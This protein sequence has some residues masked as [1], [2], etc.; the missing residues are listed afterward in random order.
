VV[1][2]VGIT[3]LHAE[4][5]PLTGAVHRHHSGH[6]LTAADA[7]AV[8][9]ALRIAA[10]WSGR[11]SVVTVAPA[12]ADPALRE[13]MA[14]GVTVLRIEPEGDAGDAWPGVEAA[15]E[16]ELARLVAG[17]IVGPGGTPELVV[18]GDRSSDRGTGAFPAF[19][20]HELGSA[21]ALGL[22]SLAGDEH[23]TGTVSGDRRLDGGWRE[24]L[25]IPCPA[26]CSV[27][28]A[29]VRLP[30]APLPALQGT[31]GAPV[32]VAAPAGH[33]G[34]AAGARGMAIGSPAPYCPRTRVLPAPADP[35]PRLR[36]LALTGALGDPDPPTGGRRPP[37][38]PWALT[39]KPPRGPGSGHPGR[40]EN[41]EGDRHLGDPGG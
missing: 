10:A 33:A 31:A 41:R 11:V 7:A 35:D 13:L 39:Q 32:P 24:R 14:L 12:S 16:R 25:R 1:A 20:A 40:R 8:E 21:H 19:L 6:A 3:D 5:D 17:A 23:G 4:V 34:S 37:A 36:L 18:C 22:V 15:D 29:G 9:H 38:R 30:R 2:C 28:G 27:E 26:V